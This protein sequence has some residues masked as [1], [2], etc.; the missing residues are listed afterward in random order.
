MRKRSIKIEA[1]HYLTATKENTYHI[2]LDTEPDSATYKWWNVFEG[3][4]SFG[5]WCIDFPTKAAA[6]AWVYDHQNQSMEVQRYES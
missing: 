3:S 2:V 6:L 4:T 1:G 5:D